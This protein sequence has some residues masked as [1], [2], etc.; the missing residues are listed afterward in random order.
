MEKYERH[1]KIDATPEQVFARLSDFTLV[2]QWMAFVINVLPM[3]E[4]HCF[5]LTEAAEETS[6]RWVAEVLECTPPRCFKYLLNEGRVRGLV[7]TTIEED[8][9]GGCKL[10]FSISDRSPVTWQG[11]PCPVIIFGED[12]ASGLAKSLGL[13][14]DLIERAGEGSK[15]DSR[16]A[17]GEGEVSD[18]LN[19]SDLSSSTQTT[20]HPL[21]VNDGPDLSD[22][23][24]FERRVADR[25]LDFGGPSELSSAE[26]Q[27]VF[28]EVSDS[29]SGRALRETQLAVR[30]GHGRAG[31]FS[32]GYLFI[33]VSIAFSSGV[34]VWSMKQSELTRGA[35]KRAESKASAEQPTAVERT[36]QAG[37][38]AAADSIGELK[39]RLSEWAEAINEGDLKGL[40]RFYAPVLERYYLQKNFPRAGVLADKARYGIGE[41]R[42]RLQISDPKID[43][44]PDG[45]RAT[46]T[47]RKGADLERQRGVTLQ[48]LIWERGDDW[49]IVSERD[50]SIR[51]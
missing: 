3:D 29:S 16:V 12:P 18:E 44:S 40:M 8:V 26:A 47:F 7:E 30:R 35:Q 15:L 46:V 31:R 2:P 39:K 27:I 41:G 19:L 45:L 43:L 6:G 51:R 13:L 9:D 49:Q 25:L 22:L 33:F 21:K 38:G 4:R 42:V 14:K 10:W 17:A 23:T 32:W 11:A 20:S 36:M 28:D 5:W 50:L 37:P 48:Q 34:F 1:I 24:P